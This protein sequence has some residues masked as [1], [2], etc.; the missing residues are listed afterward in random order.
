[1]VAEGDFVPKGD[2]GTVGAGERL[3][4]ILLERVRLTEVERERVIVTERVRVSD[5]VVVIDLLNGRVVAMGEGLLL[6]VGERV[7][8]TETVGEI[9]CVYGH[10]GRGEGVGLGEA[11]RGGLLV[12]VIYRVVTIAD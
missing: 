11:V 3:L 1:M 6:N 2:A 8:L 9:D 7:R 5:T 12:G 10:M 4:D